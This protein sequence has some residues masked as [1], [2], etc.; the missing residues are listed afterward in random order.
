MVTWGQLGRCRFYQPPFRCFCSSEQLCIKD[1]LWLTK[2]WIHLS[3][4]TQLRNSVFV[5]VLPS[6]IKWHGQTHEVLHDATGVEHCRLYRLGAS[7]TAP[8]YS[9]KNSRPELRV[10]E[11]KTEVFLSCIP[12]LTAVQGLSTKSVMIF[13]SALFFCTGFPVMIW[14]EEKKQQNR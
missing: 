3:W 14:K 8:C 10:L 12:F 5:V 2:Y 1:K 11:T 9:C 6:L 4:I 7:E 13:S